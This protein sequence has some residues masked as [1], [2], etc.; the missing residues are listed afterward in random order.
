MLPAP[1]A[2]SEGSGR[3]MRKGYSSGDVMRSR[4]TEVLE[5]GVIAGPGWCRRRDT[6]PDPSLDLAGAVAN[7]PSLENHG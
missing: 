3:G 7:Q 4:H 1:L 6:Y 2:R 5:T